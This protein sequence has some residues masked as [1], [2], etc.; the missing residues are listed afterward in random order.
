MTKMPPHTPTRGREDGS[1]SESEALA[2]DA[3]QPYKYNKLSALRAT[4]LV[5][6]QPGNRKDEVVV[7]I[8]EVDL[9]PLYTAEFK[10]IEKKL[11]ERREKNQ[12]KPQGGDSN[13]GAT[14]NGSK[15]AI[16][17]QAGEKTSKN[18]S[19]TPLPEELEQTGVPFEYEALSWNW[20]TTPW[21]SQ[22]K[23]DQDG[24]RYYFSV[25]ETIIGAFKAL[26]NKRKER[27]LWVDA[28]SIDQ[29]NNQEK[30]QQVPMM[31]EIY[32]EAKSVCVWLGEGDDDSRMAFDFI[33]NEVTKLEDF[34]KLCESPDAAPKW[35]AMFSLMKRPWFSRRWIVQEIALAREA[36][37][38]CGRKNIPWQDFADAVQ[39]FVSVESATHRLSEVMKIHDSFYHVPRWFEYV[40]RLGASLLVDATGTIFRYSKPESASPLRGHGKSKGS[41]TI[42]GAPSPRLRPPRSN[43]QALLSLEHLVS[44]LSIFQATNPRDIIYALLAIAKDTNPVAGNQTSYLSDA[45]KSI[46]VGMKLQARPYVVDYSKRYVDICA[47]FVQFAI[48]QQPDRTRALDIIC[49]PWAPEP[50][51]NDRNRTPV[52]VATALSPSDE[53]VEKEELEIMP[54]W[55]PQLYRASHNMIRHA[56][57]VEKMGRI[58]ADPLVG[59]PELNQRN[60]NAAGDKS[61]D[62][63][64]IKIKKREKYHSIDVLGFVLDRVV[65]VD[66]QSQNGNIPISW[67]NKARIDVSSFG[68]R[69]N[70]ALQKDYWDE[71]WRTLVADRGQN[72][73]NPPPYYARAFDMSLK[74]GLLATGSLNT[75]DMIDHGRCSVVSEFF[76]RVQAVIWN[77]CLIRTEKDRLGIVNEGVEKG[78]LICILDGC[79]VPVILRPTKKDRSEIE[80]DMKAEEKDLEEWSQVAQRRHRVRNRP[81]KSLRDIVERE[82]NRIKAEKAEQEEKD[83]KEREE[84]GHAGPSTLEQRLPTNDQITHTDD[85]AAGAQQNASI[86][87]SVVDVLSEPPAPEGRPISS[88]GKKTKR[89][90]TNSTDEFKLGRKDSQATL[91]SPET[92]GNDITGEPSNTPPPSLPRQERMRIWKEY[93]CQLM[94]EAFIYGVMDGEAIALYNRYLAQ[95]GETTQDDKPPKPDND[96]PNGEAGGENEYPGLQFVQSVDDLKVFVAQGDLKAQFPPFRNQ[97]F[98]LR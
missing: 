41:L 34:D 28:I 55:I 83:R 97:I 33:Q 47:D 77:R 57:S 78:D 53:T 74:K 71:F 80:K 98:E 85:T 73:R 66:K 50:K 89:S 29:S 67:F 62:L 11:A 7:K 2:E 70:S 21:T 32:G 35:N 48:N 87:N 23:V 92:Q 64:R 9:D 51:K 93:Y 26:R 60:Y 13:R 81:R 18:P 6:L 37:L 88:R 31:S 30:S 90:K 4:R 44:T 46:T 68:R 84:G 42:P 19:T 3:V 24:T 14:T 45:L 79:S 75:T 1:S 95:R 17:Q 63:T 38:Y 16:A 5:V 96:F 65:D 58:N 52:D 86:N 69:D 8:I 39:L 25:P 54:S 15:V 82:K 59:L 40:S 27:V 72:G 43:R 61:V 94:G 36:R 22:I 76:R 20:G 49:R 91:A 56:D 10:R 12:T